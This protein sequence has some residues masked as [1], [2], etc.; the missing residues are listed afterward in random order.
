MSN[1]HSTVVNNVTLTNV[2]S[3]N[4]VDLMCSATVRSYSAQTINVV[5]TFR[6]LFAVN[7]DGGICVLGRSTHSHTE[8]V[9]SGLRAM[10]R[11]FWPQLVF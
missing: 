11:K 4:I 5:P 10:Q 6:Y 7:F 2:D 3:F 8:L 9:A 1:E